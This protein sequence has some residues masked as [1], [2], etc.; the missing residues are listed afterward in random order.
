[1]GVAAVW[2]E[3]RASHALAQPA[4]TQENLFPVPRATRGRVALQSFAKENCA[5]LKFRT[6]CFPSAVS[7]RA[8]FQVKVTVEDRKSVG[9]EQFIRENAQAINGG[10]FY[11]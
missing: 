6:K 11:P 9:R 5:A 4:F 2:R 3:P 1:M 7:P 10:G 8:A